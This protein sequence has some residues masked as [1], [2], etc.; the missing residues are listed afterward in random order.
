MCSV[1]RSHSLSHQGRLLYSTF[2]KIKIKFSPVPCTLQG[3]QCGPTSK[4]GGLT[5]L[6]QSRQGKPL[7]E[8]QGSRHLL[9]RL[10]SNIL[11]MRK[12]MSNRRQGLAQGAHDQS[13]PSPEFQVSAWLFWKDQKRSAKRRGENVSKYHPRVP[14]HGTISSYLYTF[15]L[16]GKSNPPG[17]TSVSPAV[18]WKP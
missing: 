8:R 4:G 16:G 1:T 13:E 12:L 7:N 2:K 9:L 18:K 14:A 6:V 17:K 10:L 3:S 11:L 5:D 15:L